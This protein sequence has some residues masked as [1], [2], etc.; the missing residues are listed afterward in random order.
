MFLNL[1]SENI[2]WV[3][4]CSSTV[5]PWHQTSRQPNL[6]WPASVIVV[7]KTLSTCIDFPIWQ[8]HLMHDK[9]LK[10]TKF[11][12]NTCTHATHNSSSCLLYIHMS[13]QHMFSLS[14]VSQP[15]VLFMF[16]SSVVWQ[17][18]NE[19]QR[20][21]WQMLVLC[22][23][24]KQ[25]P[26]TAGDWPSILLY[27]LER[28]EVKERRRRRERVAQRICSVQSDWCWWGPRPLSIVIHCS[29]A[30]LAFISLCAHLTLML[31]LYWAAQSVLWWQRRWRWREEWVCVNGRRG[32]VCCV[33]TVVRVFAFTHAAVCCNVCERLWWFYRRR[34]WSPVR[35]GVGHDNSSGRGGEGIAPLFHWLWCRLAQREVC[36]IYFISGWKTRSRKPAPSKSY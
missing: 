19:L 7:W 22:H 20:I 25:P 28:V 27:L 2:I 33:C 29:P 35:G 32:F 36:I 21:L 6:S 17:I 4:Y 13:T 16:L 26:T 3:I 34:C 9:W 10:E 11:Y 15:H 12:Q 1:A 23:D 18:Y 24:P 14:Q 5:R 8:Q 31:R 30:L